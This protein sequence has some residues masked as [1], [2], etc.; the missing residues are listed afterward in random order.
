MSQS[1]GLFLRHQ[2]WISQN[3]RWTFSDLNP[4]YTLYT[5]DW[6]QLVLELSRE[7]QGFR[8]HSEITWFMNYKVY[9]DLRFTCR[10][11]Y[12]ISDIEDIH[13]ASIT[14]TMVSQITSVSIVYLT[15]WFRRRSKKTSKLHVTGLCEGNSPVTGEFPAQRASNTENVSIWCRHHESLLIIWTPGLS[16]VDLSQWKRR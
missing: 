3:D 2:A 15:F 14:M 4:L 8:K 1:F 11:W 5:H 13:L 9:T 6:W 7:P 16:Y 10:R 12:T